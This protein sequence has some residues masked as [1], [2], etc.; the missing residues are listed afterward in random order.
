MRDFA[1]T[2]DVAAL[3]EGTGAS[4]TQYNMHSHVAGSA[5]G[6]FT[7]IA[8]KE[9]DFDLGMVGLP[10]LVQLILTPSHGLYNRP[11]G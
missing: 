2:L 9:V 3:S 5:G 1:L 10:V 8:M 7:E 6:A 4:L 11:E